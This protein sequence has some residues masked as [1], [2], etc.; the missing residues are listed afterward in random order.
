MRED[1]SAKTAECERQA[2]ELTETSTSLTEVT[3]KADVLFNEKETLLAE[4]S[5]TIT[6]L[7]A[8]NAEL[9]IQVADLNEK[10]QKQAE[11]LDGQNK[12]IVENIG[13]CTKMTSQISELKVKLS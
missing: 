6:E 10:H 8:K 1:L 12:K 3:E 4:S 11:I 13:H 5:Q 2:A 9:E 7:R